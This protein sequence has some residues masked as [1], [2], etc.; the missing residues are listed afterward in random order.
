MKPIFRFALRYL[1]LFLLLFVVF[2]SISLIPKVGAFCNHVY[3]KPT[4][5]I[6]KALLPK[7]YLQLKPSEDSP[8]L[9][10]VEYAS[11]KQVD[12]QI[13]AAKNASKA[14]TTIA[15]MELTMKFY[16]IFLGFYIFLITLILI[17]PVSWKQKAVNILI[18]SILFYLYKLFKIY[19]TLLNT[20]SLPDIG[21]YHLNNFWNKAV[22]GILSFLTI[23]TDTVVLLVL[24]AVLTFRGKKWNQL[25]NIK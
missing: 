2:T 10:R 18:G 1:L 19:L 20:F 8:D 7:A 3:R 6:L 4:E 9:I 25:L 24:W 11:K 16:N 23:G 5:P 17:S 22:P 21:I 14:M 15:G 12:E 13:Q